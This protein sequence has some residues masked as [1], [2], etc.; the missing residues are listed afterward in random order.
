MSRLHHILLAA[1]LA[2]ST[3]AAN[4]APTTYNIVSKLSRVSFSLRHQGFIDLFGTVRLTPGHFVFDP[5]DWSRSSIQVSMPVASIDL[6]DAQWNNQ[7]RGDEAWAR[8]FMGS[9]QIGFRSTRLEKGEGGQGRLFGDLT[10][11]GVTRPVVLELRF[12]KLGLNEVSEKPSVG[13]SASTRI[14][15]SDFGLDAYLDLVGDEMAIQIQ[16]EGTEGVDTDA[17]NST[18]ALG[19]KSKS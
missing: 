12:N 15:R 18:N 11:A 5:E 8:L 10:L 14:K 4:A 16:V 13:F 3:A 17:R 2:C 19:V 9:R 7:V 1:A 6:G